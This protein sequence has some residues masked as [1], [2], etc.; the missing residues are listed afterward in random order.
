MTCDKCGGR[1][2]WLM[3]VGEHACLC[4]TAIDPTVGIS[5]RIIREYDPGLDWARLQMPRPMPR[6]TAE[7]TVSWHLTVED[8]DLLRSMQIGVE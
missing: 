1:T 7:P 4:G 2:D 3:A 8:R 5:L 6:I